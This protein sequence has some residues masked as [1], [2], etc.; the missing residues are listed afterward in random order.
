[1]TRQENI[2]T[3]QPIAQ[4]IFQQPDLNLNIQAGP[5]QIPNWTSLTFTQFLTEIENHLNIKFKMLEIIRMRTT[6]DIID[7]TLTHLQA[8]Q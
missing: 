1:M 7:V 8:N 6:Q 2:N 5:Q 4:Q 3:L